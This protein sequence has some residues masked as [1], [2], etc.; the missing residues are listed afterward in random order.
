MCWKSQP[1]TFSTCSIEPKQFLI[2]GFVLNLGTQLL[3]NLCPRECDLSLGCFGCIV[4]PKSSPVEP[5]LPK[6]EGPVAVSQLI[7]IVQ[8]CAATGMPTPDTTPTWGIIRLEECL[9]YQVAV[10]RF[11]P[12]FLAPSSTPTL[13]TWKNISGRRWATGVGWNPLKHILVVAYP[14]FALHAHCLW[15]C[16]ANDDGSTKGFVGCVMSK[17]CTV[18]ICYDCVQPYVI[19]KGCAQ[20]M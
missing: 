16:S 7:S 9:T 11:G 8:I 20:T 19:E 13:G 3:E 1:N 4:I 12:F 15:M 10:I 2:C 17:L 6:S 18:M 14:L 5:V